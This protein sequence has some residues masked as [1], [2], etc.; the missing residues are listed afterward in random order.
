[1]FVGLVP[2]SAHLLAQY[3]D[4]QFGMLVIGLNTALI[5]LSLYAMRNYVLY[6]DRIQNNEVTPLSVRHGTIRILVPVVCAIVAMVVS[7]VSVQVGLILFT[8]GVIF[9][10]IP[11]SASILEKVFYRSSVTS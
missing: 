9:N 7:F 2:F 8:L 1:M 5:G 6:S 10:F 3:S 11:Q 4:T